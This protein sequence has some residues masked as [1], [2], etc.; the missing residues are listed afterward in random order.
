MVHNFN[1]YLSYMEK[2]GYSN[3]YKVLD[4]RDYGIP[5]ARERCFTVSILGDNAFD[6]ELMGKKTHE[7]HFKIFLNTVMFLIATW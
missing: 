5:Q 6:F 7:K 1:R 3:N 4:C 2:L